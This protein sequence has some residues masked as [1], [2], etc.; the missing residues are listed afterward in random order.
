MCKIKILKRIILHM[1]L[2]HFS[3]KCNPRQIWHLW[4]LL[5]LYQNGNASFSLKPPR[6]CH[7][8]FVHCQPMWLCQ[9]LSC[10]YQLLFGESIRWSV[11]HWWLYPLMLHQLMLHPLMLYLLKLYQLKLYPLMLLSVEAL[12]SSVEALILI[13]WRLDTYQLT[14]FHLCK[15]TRHDKFT[16]DLP[17]LHIYLVVNMTY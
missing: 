5:V 3:V 4:I 13:R 11:I 9:L 7:I 6:G 15:I 8:P 14:L 16:I 12:E 17:I 10:H 1:L 2:F